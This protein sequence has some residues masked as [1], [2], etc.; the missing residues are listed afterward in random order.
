MS[1]VACLLIYMV[2]LDF[3]IIVQSKAKTE[4][5]GPQPFLAFHVTPHRT[6]L[7]ETV[8]LKDGLTKYIQ[9]MVTKYTYTTTQMNKDAKFSKQKRF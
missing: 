5:V 8:C 2:R 9:V 1:P 4:S 3:P 6:I 7:K